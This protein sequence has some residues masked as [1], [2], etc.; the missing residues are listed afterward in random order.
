VLLDGGASWIASNEKR[1]G[2]AAGCFA[3]PKKAVQFVDQPTV[4]QD[5]K[6]T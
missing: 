1:V 5:K 3:T 2:N 6:Q 4:K